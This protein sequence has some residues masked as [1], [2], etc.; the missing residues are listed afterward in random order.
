MIQIGPPNAQILKSNE[1]SA[2]SAKDVAD[3]VL[4][5]KS[6]LVMSLIVPNLKVIKHNSSAIMFIL[7]LKSIRTWLGHKILKS[8]PSSPTE[9]APYICL[10]Q[11]IFMLKKVYDMVNA[12]LFS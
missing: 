1:K 5:D 10:R 11:P 3:S 8:P 12:E 7:V 6:S 2:W 4:A 9:Q